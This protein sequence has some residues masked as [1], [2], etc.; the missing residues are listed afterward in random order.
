MSRLLMLE[1]WV[2]ANG[3]LLPQR[4]K[5]MGH[6]YVLAT[7]S[8]NHYGTDHD[9]TPHPVL[10][11][12][13]EILSVETNDVRQILDAVR[14]RR[15][16]GVITICD[17]YIETT[18]EVSRS[19]GLPC[20]FPQGVKNIRRKDILR[21]TLD[22]TGI[23]N[24]QHALCSC[25]DETKASANRLSYPLVIKPV[26]LASSAFVRLI[27]D[28]RELQDAFAALEAFTVNFR[29]QPRERLILLEE[30]LDGPEFSVETVISRGQPTTLGIT[31]KSVTGSPRF[32][33]D[34]HMFPAPLEPN[35]EQTV[36]DYVNSVLQALQFEY[37]VAHTEIK[38]TA[39]GPKIVEINVRP[40]GNYI[41]ELVEIVTGVDILKAFVDLSLG[42]R[43]VV[44]RRNTGTTSAA[45]AFL[46]PNG[47]GI[48]KEMSG[49]D[50]MAR[51]PHVHRWS[52]EDL[53]GTVVH[54]A[55]DN[56]SYLGHVLT[57][58]PLG[59]EARYHAESA[60]KRVNLRF[61]HP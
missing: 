43:P 39:N 7:R 17:Y 55:V 37:G 57:V 52:M 38:L 20:P 58:D 5:E 31:D 23:P 1:S 51:A 24:V 4:I 21:A 30:Y 50:V 42:Q 9:G 35:V 26:D 10:A 6:S 29:D 46:V 54:K 56:A 32:I 8:P 18:V 53:T 47:W 12:A 16:D 3:R 59:M 34:G 19:M 2:G 41:A 28:E 44:E 45:V 13:D 11:L 15:F 33:E 49:I 27:H 40:A 25:W 36:M 60:L 61:E 14:G 48:I 22:R